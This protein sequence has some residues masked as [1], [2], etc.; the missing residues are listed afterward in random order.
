MNAATVLMPDTEPSWR[1]WPSLSAPRNETVESPSEFREVS[2]DLIVGLP[3]TACRSIGM[4]LPEAEPEILKSM[5]EAQLERRGITIDQDG[6]RTHVHHLLG[7]SGGL[8]MISVDV[9]ASPFPDSL[10]VNHAANYTSALRMMSLP[11]SELAL[12][13]E[14]GHIVLAANYLG[15]LWQSYVIGTIETSVADVA[16]ELE[17]T[18][19]SLEA[20]EGFGA[21]RGVVLVGE[22]LGQLKEELKKFTTLP[23][24]TISSLQPNQSV[25]LASFTKLL[26]ASVYEAQAARSRRAL[27]A[28]I[29]MLV[30][31]LYVVLFIAGWAYLR[32]L[33]T[34]EAAL[35]AEVSTNSSAAASVKHSAKLWHALEPAINP[36]HYPIVLLSQVT[37]LMPPS[38]I[39][40][41][42]FEVKINE[43]EIRGDARDP[44]TASQ[45]YADLKKKLDLYSG[46]DMPPP[47]VKDKIASF[48]ITGKIPAA[49][50]E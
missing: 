35:E 14:Q 36:K 17:L 11:T 47:T 9:L 4:I 45:F 7:H 38:G 12:V 18:A 43:I 42:R 2:K 44:Q 20:Q 22:R 50:N 24:S 46:W 16:R 8:V 39:V 3:A 25:K 15:K 40:L 21:I 26:P 34:K 6:L 31:A 48:K 33:K 29:G 30:A 19:M 1:F 27:Y 10:A 32:V 49:N 37:S 28:R 41:K 23:A 13:E 5:I